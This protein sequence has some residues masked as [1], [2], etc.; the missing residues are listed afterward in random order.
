MPNKED[1]ALM[2]H[3]TRR[4]GFGASRGEVE[5]LVEQGYQETVEQLLHPEQRPKFDENTLY[6]YLP[7]AEFP[8]HETHS[9]LDWLYRMANTMRPLQ[10]KLALFWH[11]VFATA[12]SKVEGPPGCGRADSHVPPVWHGELQRPACP[13]G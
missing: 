9:Q 13:A 1:I 5:R 11:H 10:E 2:A 4:A 7:M 12:N 8:R 6:R 3:L